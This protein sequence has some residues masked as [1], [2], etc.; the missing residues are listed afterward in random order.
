MKIAI[1]MMVVLMV[2]SATIADPGNN[3]NSDSQT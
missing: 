1:F 2:A 3:G